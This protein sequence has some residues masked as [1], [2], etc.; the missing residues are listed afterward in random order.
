MNDSGFFYTVYIIQNKLINEVNFIMILLLITKNFMLIQKKTYY[1][2]NN[3]NIN[4]DFNF[5]FIIS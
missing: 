2:L 3:L 5:L 1:Q 4:W